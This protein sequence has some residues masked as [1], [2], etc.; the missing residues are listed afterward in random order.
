MAKKKR[1]YE[2]N[3]A[4]M[5]EIASQLESQSVSLEAS[6]QLYQEGMELA[7]ECRKALSEAETKVQQLRQDQ[8]GSF[9]TV[10]FTEE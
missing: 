10:P 8:L 2:E 3:M 1:T 4:R 5:E 9:E 6:I 7:L